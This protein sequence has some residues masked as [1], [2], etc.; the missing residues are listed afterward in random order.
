V[1]ASNFKAAV[2]TNYKKPCLSSIK[3]LCYPDE[4]KFSTAATVRGCAYETDAV[5]EFLDRFMVDRVDVELLKVELVVNEKY[6]YNALV[7]GNFLRK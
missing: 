1:T 3:R 5:G 4:Y 6:L 2:R 7:M